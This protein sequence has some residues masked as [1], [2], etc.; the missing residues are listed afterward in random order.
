MN[1]YKVAE[2]FLQAVF[3]DYEARARF[4]GRTLTRGWYERHSLK[5][6]DLTGDCFLSIAAFPPGVPRQVGHVEEVRC[7]VI[8]DVGEFILDLAVEQALGTPTAIVSSS[9]G[10]CH[11]WYRLATPVPAGEWGPFIAGIEARLGGHKLHGSETHHVFRLP[12]GVYSNPDK[13]DR[14]GFEPALIELNPGARLDPATITPIG[15]VATAQRPADGEGA[16]IKLGLDDLR[17]G[18]SWLKNDETFDERNGLW[19]NVIGHGLK[20]LCKDDEDGFTVFD[21]WSHTH[22]KYN[23]GL[24]RKAWNS[25]GAGGL[26]SKAG[27]LKGLWQKANP[28]GFAKM[29]ARHVFEDSADPPDPFDGTAGRYEPTHVGMAE[30]VVAAEV[31]GLGWMDTASERWLVFCPVERRWLASGTDTFMRAAVRLEVE[32]RLAV[33]VEPKVAARLREAKWRGAV[34]G[35]LNKEQRLMLDMRTFDVELDAVGMRGKVLRL[36]EAGEAVERPGAA[37]DRITKTLGCSRVL[38][39][40]HQLRTTAPVW[41]SFLDDF[42]GGDPKL[43]HWWQAFCGYCLT[44]HTTEE[45]VVFVYGPGGNGKSVFLD[46][47]GEVMGDYHKRADHRLFMEKRGGFHLA[48]LADLE[49]ARLVTVPDVRPGDAWDMGLVKL[50]SG[51]GEVTANKMRQDPFSYQPQFKIVLAGNDK[52][53]LDMV[54][55]GVRRRMRLVPATFKPLVADPGLRAKLRKEMPYILAWMVEGWEQWSK[56]R[57]PE[58]PEITKTTGIYMDAADVWGRWLVDAVKLTGRGKDK[59]RI[60]EAWDA[61]NGFRSEEGAYHTPPNNAQ[62]VSARLSGELP[63]DKYVIKRDNK[64]AYIE[65]ATLVKIA[66]DVF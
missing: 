63:K 27:K 33:G 45:I 51:G 38:P 65:G 50:V 26:T 53:R 13:A 3:P 36:R 19:V 18:M 39:W 60:K 29:F 1:P 2:Q 41:T 4:A 5:A 11:W 24:V 7:L 46:T 21:E 9:T 8:D 28:D 35:L 31:G 34:C 10:S 48:P 32:R 64:G 61:W 17:L 25:F 57:L 56:S 59:V 14:I 49:G 52:P 6:L 42:C 37:D 12:M 15:P 30:Y 44:G 55:D 20:A 43:K 22:Y 54:D 58:C 62:E 47:I 40:P 16:D 66:A 23:A